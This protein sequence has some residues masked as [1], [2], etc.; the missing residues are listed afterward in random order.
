MKNT[1]RPTTLSYIVRMC[2]GQE[3]SPYETNYGAGW[4]RKEPG[5]LVLVP[6]GAECK[7]RGNSLGQFES[8]FISFPEQELQQVAGELLETEGSY[9]RR[10]PNSEMH[11]PYLATLLKQ[12]WLQ[13]GERSPGGELMAEGTFIS[14]LGR[15][16]VMGE[17]KSKSRTLHE[18]KGSAIVSKTRE[19][20]KENLAEKVTL[21]DL[22][23]AAG[24]SRSYLTRVFKKETGQTVHSALLELRVN[25]AKELMN[26][27]GRN[28]TLAEVADGCGFANHSHL[29]L[30]FV[31]VVGTTPQN[32][33]RHI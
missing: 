18:R 3:S 29:T 10:A 5:S 31:Q 30:A 25:R 17:G 11:D 16:F 1:S 8:L 22:A 6:P 23:V 4:F 13:C 33:R 24:V 19:Y 7:I 32:Y 2:L 27:F 26:Y 15:L 12:L 9:L 28:L 21:G 20:L 14:L